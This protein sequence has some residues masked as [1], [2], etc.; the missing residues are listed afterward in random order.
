MKNY[1]TKQNKWTDYSLSRKQ[2]STAILEYLEKRGKVVDRK[3]GV[4][5]RSGWWGSYLFV[6]V[7]ESR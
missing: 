1:K 7:R 3:R 6:R 2:Q 4:Q 5:E